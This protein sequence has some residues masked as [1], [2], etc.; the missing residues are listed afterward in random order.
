MEEETLMHFSF[1]LSSGRIRDRHLGEPE[2]LARPTVVVSVVIAN[3]V[4]AV[5]VGHRIGVTTM[6]LTIFTV[7][8]RYPLQRRPSR[9][10]WRAPKAEVLYSRSGLESRTVV[11][12][13]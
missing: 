2:V 6:R 3:S 9:S 12:T 7:N 11:D 10:R 8:G 4:D 13:R 1:V 5:L